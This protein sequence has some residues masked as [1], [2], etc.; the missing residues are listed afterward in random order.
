MKLDFHHIGVACLDLQSETRRFEILGY[1]PEGPDFTDPLQGVSGRFLVGGGP[2]M[3]LLVP[4]SGD[5][6]LTPWIKSG[7]K[8]YHLAYETPDLPS[9]IDFYRSHRSK[10]VVQPVEAVAFGGRL[11][12]FLM[13]PNMLLVELIESPGQHE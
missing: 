13:M 11:I 4:L 6:V 10:I 2:R 5:G 8:L 7:V 1:T 12:C 9:A 3:E